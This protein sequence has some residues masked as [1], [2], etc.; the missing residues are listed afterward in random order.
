M[1]ILQS[2]C[3]AGEEEKRNYTSGTHPGVMELLTM[4]RRVKIQDIGG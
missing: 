1:Q 2:Y 3:K 4:A